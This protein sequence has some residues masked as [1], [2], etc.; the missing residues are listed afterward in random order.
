MTGKQQIHGESIDSSGQYLEKT[1][2]PA[3]LV[4]YSQ[5]TD[6]NIKSNAPERP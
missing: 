1:L 6:R 2:F 3:R 5:L 4:N